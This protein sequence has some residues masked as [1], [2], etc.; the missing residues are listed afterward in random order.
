MAKKQT[1]NIKPSWLYDKQGN[2]RKVHPPINGRGET[3]SLNPQ[4]MT[5]GL[6]SSVGF[7][8]SSDKQL[9]GLR[10]EYDANVWH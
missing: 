9:Q 8:M 6:H 2:I 4:T 10:D 5:G 3:I 7:S 1:N